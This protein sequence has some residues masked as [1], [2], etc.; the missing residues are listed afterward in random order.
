M[1]PR[2]PLQLLRASLALAASAT[3]LSGCLQG[4]PVTVTTVVAG[5]TNPWDVGFAGNTMIYTE[6]PGRIS[7]FVS[8]Q[9]RLLAAPPDVVQASEAGMMGLAVDPQFAS[10]RLIFTC[11]ASRLGGPANDVRVTRWRVNEDF[12]GLTGRTDIVTGIPVNTSGE[13]GRHSGCR[14]RFGP[15]GQLWI[16]TGD[17]AIGSVPQDPRSL[18]GKILHVTRDGSPAPNNPTGVGLDPR[19]WSYGHRNVQGLAWRSSDGLGVSTEHGPDTDDELNLVI[20]GNFGWD[21]VPSGGG[22]G[23]NEAV[24]M[25]DRAKFPSAVPAVWSSGR[26]TQAPSGITFLSGSRW[27]NWNGALAGAFL[28]SSRLVIAQVDAQGRLGDLGLSI[29][30]QGRL[31]TPV[32]GPDGNLYVTTDNGGGQDK[33]LRIAPG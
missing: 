8:G 9:K 10:S 33:I 29:T 12:T 19:I 1:L 25:T 20:W 5:L 11:H 30:D 32:Q 31:R 17:A 18:G 14:P 22:A 16:G 13:L 6:R 2:R 23:Y 24:P 21:P 7:A 26:P 3:L 15:D 27:G 4:P 28:K